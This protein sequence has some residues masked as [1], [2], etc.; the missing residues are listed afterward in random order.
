M[1]DNNNHR[2]FK[3]RLILDKNPASSGILSSVST[4]D[5]AIPMPSY[6]DIMHAIT[7][8]DCAHLMESSAGFFEEILLP[9][10]RQ[11]NPVLIYADFSI[12]GVPEDQE[13]LLKEGCRLSCPGR[14]FT[15]ASHVIAAIGTIGSDLENHVGAAFQS[16]D[17]FYAVA[18]DAVG[19]IMLKRM[20]EEF[21][22]ACSIKAAEANMGIGPRVSPGC[23][24]T[25]LSCQ[26]TLFSLLD[27]SRIG[28]TLS[29]S[30]LMS[31]IKSSSLFFPLGERIPASLRTS[32]S[33]KFCDF[34]ERCYSR[35]V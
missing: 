23:Y 4:V 10:E 15:G 29:S 28:V 11:I 14:L 19:S 20:I 35:Y 31:P 16:G 18:L 5:L 13:V 30:Y 7:K 9:C 33:C 2:T 34:R 1:G 24:R 12:L 22:K 6:C 8:E 21:Y 3:V 27:A 25:S 26:K 32:D 17:P